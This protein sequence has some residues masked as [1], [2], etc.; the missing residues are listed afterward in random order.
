MSPVSLLL[1]DPQPPNLRQERGRRFTAPEKER[2]SLLASVHGQGKTFKPRCQWASGIQHMWGRRQHCGI[3][4]PVSRHRQVCRVTHNQGRQRCARKDHSTGLTVSRIPPHSCAEARSDRG[5]HLASPRTAV[6]LEKVL[7]STEECQLSHQIPPHSLKSSLYGRTSTCER[8]RRSCPHAVC[9]LAG[10][11]GIRNTCMG[12]AGSCQQ[13]PDTAAHSWTAAQTSTSGSDDSLGCATLSLRHSAGP[14][15]NNLLSTALVLLAGRQQ[16]TGFSAAL[17]SYSLS[18][19][20]TLALLLWDLYPPKHAQTL[21]LHYSKTRTSMNSTLS[22]S[23]PCIK[24]RAP[25]N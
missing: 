6:S 22:H 18:K 5:A 2:D 12:T 11:E 8:G 17:Y 1:S 9:S 19:V 24:N 25:L 16:T 14:H 21:L 10:A 15:W 3:S 23:M 13:V 4:G 7:P 20:I